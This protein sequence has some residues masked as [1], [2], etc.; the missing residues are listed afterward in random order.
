MTLRRTPLKCLAFVVALI[1]S[2]WLCPP[3]SAASDP[4]LE[5]WTL[6]T[7][8][9]RIHYYK[10]LEPVAH[11]LTIPMILV[12]PIDGVK[13]IRELMELVKRLPPG[14]PGGTPDEYEV[15]RVVVRGQRAALAATSAPSFH[16]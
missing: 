4:Y 12:A 1:G 8:H 16:R 9:F 14:V 13:S 6:E 15:L 11:F 3:A 2:L 7:A 10:G 5:W